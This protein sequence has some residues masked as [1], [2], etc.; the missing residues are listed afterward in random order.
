MGQ[1][2]DAAGLGSKGRQVQRTRL[3]YPPWLGVC[4]QA[5]GRLCHSP[6]CA[7]CTQEDREFLN[8]AR[9]A[10]KE[11]R[12]AQK[13]APTCGCPPLRAHVSVPGVWQ[14]GTEGMVIRRRKASEEAGP[15]RCVH[16]TGRQVQ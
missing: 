4:G 6:G 9:A 10:A 7:T 12:A 11:A 3:P 8:K 14:R 5:G 13:V 2:P 15:S 1:G 16:S